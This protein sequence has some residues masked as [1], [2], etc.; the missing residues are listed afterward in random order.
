MDEVSCLGTD[1]RERLEH[2]EVGCVE[3]T[4]QAPVMLLLVGHFPVLCHL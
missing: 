1:G 4:E 3:D 2:L